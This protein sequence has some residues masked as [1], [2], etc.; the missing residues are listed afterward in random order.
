MVTPI[1]ATVGWA[2]WTSITFV[3]SGIGKQIINLISITGKKTRGLFLDFGVQSL[4]TDGI[5]QN[6]IENVRV[7]FCS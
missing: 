4:W 7:N 1:Q 2:Q 6:R 5:K 3:N